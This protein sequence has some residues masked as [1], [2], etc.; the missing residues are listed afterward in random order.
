M[1]I[2]KVNPNIKYIYH[3]TLKKNIN[4]ILKDKEIKSIDQYIFFTKNLKDCIK[5]FDKEMMQENKIYIDQYCN[6]RKRE[7]CNKGDYCILKIPYIN[8]KE[9]YKFE[10]DNKNSIY[11]ISL[12][13]KGKYKFE[14][15]QILEFPTTNKLNIFNKKVLSYLTIATCIVL[16]PYNV[17]ASSWLDE[18]NY[19]ISWYNQNNYSYTINTPQELA[20][21]AYLVN[22]SNIT[23]EGKQIN[24]D[25]DINL[26]EHNWETIKDIFK[27]N[28]CGSHR[29]ILNYLDKKL[30]EGNNIDLISYA[31]K[32]LIDTDTLIDVIIDKPYTVGTL[33]QLTN[34]KTIFYNNIELE[35]N[36][37]LL[38][39]I[40][41][42][43]GILEGFTG[44][45]IYVENTKEE[46]IP[47]YVE[48]GD[49]IEMVK[50][51]YSKKTNIPI[52]KLIIKY[53]NKELKN[54]KTL[55]DYNIQ[56][57]STIYIYE[58]FNI[59][60]SIEQGKGNIITT[61]D[62][63]IFKDNI[64]ITLT[65]EIE[66]IV[67]KILINDI[68]KTNKLKNNKLNIECNNEDINIKVYYKLKEVV[69]PTDLENTTELLIENPKTSDNIIIYIKT[70]II[71][72]ISLI[73]LKIKKVKEYKNK[74][75]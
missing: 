75:Y 5:V 6:L 52:D 13:H 32:M 15:I 67:D 37:S 10:F 14:D 35:D 58:K 42:K 30:I 8:D 20:G 31:Y 21:L 19:D 11:E 69:N 47:L 48:S 3:Y 44:R 54:E 24:I 7:K 41:E 26:L 56:K 16:F 2:K 9:F 28:I 66:Y 36:I 72:F 27:G 49:S 45:F 1:N 73:I 17:Y 39:L 23:F 43:K 68:D 38:E 25:K 70:L 29:I 50:E 18:N 22:N 33:K 34:T 55:A 53:D 51:K 60:K 63:V 62:T 57:L 4:K 65:P 40:N 71:S 12:T 59:Y 46:K 61:Q 64:T 74:N